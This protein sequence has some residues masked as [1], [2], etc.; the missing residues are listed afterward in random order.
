MAEMLKIAGYSTVG[1]TIPTG[2]FRDRVSSIRRIFEREGLDTVIRIDLASTS[3][4]ELLKSLRRYRKAFDLVSVKCINPRVA[5]V[6][7]RDRRVD[8]IFFD[9]TNRSLRFSHSLAGLLRGALELNLISNLLGQPNSST[10]ASLVKVAAIAREHNVKLVLSSG[11]RNPQMVRTPLQITALGSALG[12]S[13][14]E[15]VEGVT[16]APMSIVARNLKKRRPEYVEEGV[17][18]VAPTQR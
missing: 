10:F 2:L 15:T 18:V 5:T 8:I 12:L 9:G 6:A 14:Q 3:R 13:N 17:R 16:L 1:L 4:L 7:S 11:S